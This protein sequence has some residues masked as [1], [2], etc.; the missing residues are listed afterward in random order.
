MDFAIA[1]IGSRNELEGLRG[2]WRN[3]SLNLTAYPRSQDLVLDS[4]AIVD[5]KPSA[6]KPSILFI[7]L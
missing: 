1:A 7:P 6:I 4:E 5:A 3:L 2:K